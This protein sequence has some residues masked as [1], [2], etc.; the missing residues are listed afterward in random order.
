VVPQASLIRDPGT[1]VKEIPELPSADHV[2][3]LL[4]GDRCGSRAR[5]PGPRRPG[6]RRPGTD[7]SRGHDE[8]PDAPK[9]SQAIRLM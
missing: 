1:I 9:E 2:M 5:R 7:E 8:R 6:P 3:G 4:P